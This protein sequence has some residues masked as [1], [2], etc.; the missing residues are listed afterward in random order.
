VAFAAWAAGHLEAGVAPAAVAALLA[1][2]AGGMVGLRIAGPMRTAEIA[3][4]GAHW[5]VDGQAGELQLMMDLQRWL[6]LRQRRQPSGPARW[7]VVSAAGQPGALRA[8]RTALYSRPLP[9]VADPADPAGPTRS[10]GPAPD[11]AG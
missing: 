6:M 7:I 10:A 4:D 2:A 8:L 1:A 9:T 11:K 5:R 3:W